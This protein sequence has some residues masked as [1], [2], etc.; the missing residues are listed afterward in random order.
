MMKKIIITLGTIVA[1]TNVVYAGGKKVAPVEAEVLPVPAVINPIP[2]YLGI[3]VI[4]SAVSK[5]CPCGNDVRQKDMT[6]GAILRAGWDFNKYIGIEGRVLRANI[7]KDFSTTTHYGLYLKPQYHFIDS[8]NVYGLLGYGKTKVEG[9]GFNNGTLSKNGFSYGAGFE[10]DLSS[11][12][13][14]GQYARDFD[15]QGNQEKGWGLWADYQNL[16]QNEGIFKVKTNIFSVG[17][18]YD[19]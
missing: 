12:T 4:A 8:M 9:C 7:E 6:Y 14:A 18:T 13:S 2:I 19:F 5:E 17:I 10:Y 16:F 15:G 1:L 11:D 3:G